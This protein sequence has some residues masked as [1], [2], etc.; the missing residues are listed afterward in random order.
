MRVRNNGK[1]YRANASASVRYD[2]RSIGS[3]GAKKIGIVKCII[4]TPGKSPGLSPVVKV[5]PIGSVLF[6]SDNLLRKW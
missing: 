5:G 6:F 4:D 3:R 2:N 1:T